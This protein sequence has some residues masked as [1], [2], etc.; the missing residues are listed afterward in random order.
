LV[1]LAFV[2][3]AVSGPLQA[4]A[5]EVIVDSVKG[6]RLASCATY[7]W[8]KGH[9][10]QDPF[11]DERIVDAVDA[12][13][14]RKGWKKIE[15]GAACLVAY[16]ASVKD[17]KSV[18]VW[19]PGGWRFRGGF[20]SV[21]IRTV[22][23]GMLVVDVADAA[24]RRLLWRGIARDTLG[25]KPETNQKKLAKATQKMFKELPAATTADTAATR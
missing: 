14:A 19:E 17:E 6:S 21:D 25:D 24:S 5:Q 18:Q 13:L 7:S 9:P 15:D 12:A 11:V 1:R 22:R 4:S 3:T 16:H 23:S 20:A 2:A 10:A 8:S